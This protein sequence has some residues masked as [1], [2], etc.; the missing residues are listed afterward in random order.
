MKINPSS[1]RLLVCNLGPSGFI[2]VALATQAFCLHKTFKAKDVK[3]IQNSNS[4]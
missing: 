4:K 3:S 2:L 1:V